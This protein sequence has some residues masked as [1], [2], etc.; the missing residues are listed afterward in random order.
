VRLA[1]FLTKRQVETIHRGALRV[2]AEVGVRVEHE[3]V[4]KR[5]TRAG[6]QCGAGQA[7]RFP[8]KTVERLIAEAPKRKPAR[9]RATVSAR[10]GVYGSRY[11]DPATDALLDFDE[12]RLGRYAALA[13]SMHHVQDTNILGVPFPV[14]GVPAAY[15]PLAE[16]LYA[17]K[18]GLRPGGSVLFT[19]L[20]EPLLEMFQCHAAAHGRSTEEVFA[21]AGYMISPLRLARPE[22]EQLLFFAERGLRMWIGHLPSQG[23]TAPVS[24]AGAMVLAL[25]EQLFLYLLSRSFWDQAEL[26]LGGEVAVVD[27]RRGC[28]RY[29]RPEQQRTN[30]AFADVARF[31][32]CSCRGHTGGTDAKLPSHEAGAQKAAGA[33]LTALATGH[34]S[35]SAGLLSM[36]EICSPVQMVL[37]DDLTGGLKALLAG[38]VVDETECAFQEILAAGPGGN[39]LGTEFTARRFRK[40]LYQPRTW[41]ADNLSAWQAVGRKADVDLAR[42]IVLDF[43]RD[44]VAAACISPAE[45][46]ELQAI[47][48]RAV[49]RELAS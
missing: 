11:L 27:M 8:S 31:Y 49:Q 23:G 13:R 14:E 30:A 33:L 26:A 28:T 32:G 3:A 39:H 36:D 24:F 4:R 25:A 41:S 22:C 35:I 38:P 20:C 7:V 48:R 18:H 10:V 21:A 5:L 16:K 44:F 37:D 19:G 6:G 2:L 46:K 29:G 15:Q 45:E 34:G 42:E 47:I 17:W 40:C 1:A 9:A 43:E 12:D